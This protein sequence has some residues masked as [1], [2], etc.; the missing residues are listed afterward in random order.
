MLSILRVLGPLLFSAVGRFGF[1]IAFLAFSRYGRRVWRWF[2][3]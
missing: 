3:E 1:V 2:W